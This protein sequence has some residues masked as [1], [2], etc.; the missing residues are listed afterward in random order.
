MIVCLAQQYKG[1]STLFDG[2]MGDRRV[3]VVTM[4]RDTKMYWVISGGQLIQLTNN[5]TTLIVDEAGRAR[6]RTLHPCKE[7]SLPFF[8]LDAVDEKQDIVQLFGSNPFASSSMSTQLDK[9]TLQSNR[10]NLPKGLDLS[11]FT[12]ILMGKGCF[13]IAGRYHKALEKTMAKSQTKSSGYVLL[14][15]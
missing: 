1:T 7:I 10:L 3:E 14:S 4:S 5:A 15:C 2:D 11:H 6:V 9:A 8:A 12:R 13:A